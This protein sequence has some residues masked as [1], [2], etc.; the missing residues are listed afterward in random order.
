MP[1]I[2]FECVGV[3]KSFKK[4]GGSHIYIYVYVLLG[5]SS[6]NAFLCFLRFMGSG[7]NK[8]AVLSAHLRRFFFWG[9]GGLQRRRRINII[10]VG[11]ETQLWWGMFFVVERT[12]HILDV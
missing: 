8:E 7:G 2:F 6:A 3:K 1:K 4:K 5:I 12:S 10:G 11:S 9:K